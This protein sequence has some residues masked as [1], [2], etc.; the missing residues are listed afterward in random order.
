MTLRQHVYLN[1]F[2]CEYLPHKPTL[3]GAAYFLATGKMDADDEE[4]Y[5]SGD[6]VRPKH[7]DVFEA[8]VSTEVWAGNREYAAA[9]PPHQW[10][11]ESFGPGLG[12]SPEDI[13]QSLDEAIEAGEPGSWYV[14][15]NDSR[16]KFMF[17]LSNPDKPILTPPHK[18]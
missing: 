12:W 9:C 6:D 15:L 8:T 16:A 1:K 4:N 5:F 10:A 14:A 2:A 18:E 3:E 13:Y 11:V 17:D 7:G